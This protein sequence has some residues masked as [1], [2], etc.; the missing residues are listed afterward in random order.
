[1]LYTQS[2]L[3][4][5]IISNRKKS[6]NNQL[7]KG[8]VWE[9]QNSSEVFKS[10]FDY[11]QHVAHKKLS[12]KNVLLKNWS[13]WAKCIFFSKL[14]FVSSFTRY[15]NFNQRYQENA[16]YSMPSNP[17]YKKIGGQIKKSGSERL[18]QIQSSFRKSYLF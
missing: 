12:Q 18:L 16:I 5:K 4:I 11:Y 9:M 2:M 8:K 3:F 17:I 15:L 6:K 13:I 1:M 10:N 14:S 7:S